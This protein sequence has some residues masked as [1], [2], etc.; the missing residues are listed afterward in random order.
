M[1]EIRIDERLS[2]IALQE[3]KA[4][5][6]YGNVRINLTKKPNLFMRLFLKLLG[7]EVE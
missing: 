7:V 6:V 4:S 2:N 3:Y 5:L 1:N